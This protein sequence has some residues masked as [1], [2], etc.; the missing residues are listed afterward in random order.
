MCIISELKTSHQ[1]AIATVG[2]TIEALSQHPLGIIKNSRQYNIKVQ[3]N[4]SFLYKGL[5]IGTSAAVLYQRHFSKVKTEALTLNSRVITSQ[6]AGIIF[7][8]VLISGLL[9]G[10]GIITG[11]PGFWNL[12]Y[13]FDLDKEANIPTLFSSLLALL[14][15]EESPSPRSLLWCLLCH[16]CWVGHRIIVGY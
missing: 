12:A 10:I 16:H 9:D 7:L 3:W 14:G 2:S 4:P 1:I 6:L 13:Q 5:T 8:F 11:Q 15:P